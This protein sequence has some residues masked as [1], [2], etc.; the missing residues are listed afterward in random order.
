MPRRTVPRAGREQRRKT[1][2]RVRQA[3]RDFRCVGCR[4]DVPA[5]APGT[6]H[7]NHCP[8]CLV[9]LH[10]DRRVP[11]DRGATCRGRMDALS[12]SARPDGEWMIVH[13]CAA[14][15]ELSVNRIAGDD[16]ALALVRLALRPLRD[17][18]IAKALLTL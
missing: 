3:A 4:L 13:E 5:S 10:V 9:S 1:V 8:T 6:A 17:P 2:E 11:G 18:H 12:V 16:N 14:C 7:R 15:G